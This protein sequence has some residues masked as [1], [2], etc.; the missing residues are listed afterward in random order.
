MHFVTGVEFES[1]CITL[2]P[3]H[4]KKNTLFF[5]CHKISEG[6]ATSQM[7]REVCKSLLGKSLV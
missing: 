7:L 1:G 4:C 6:V 5:Q 3:K 2:D